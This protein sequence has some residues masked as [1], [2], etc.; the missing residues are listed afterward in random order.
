MFVQSSV[1]G[2]DTSLS[3]LLMEITEFTSDAL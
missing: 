3:Q 1:H 2:G